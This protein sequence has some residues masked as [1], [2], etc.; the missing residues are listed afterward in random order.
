VTAARRRRLLARLEDGS[1]DILVGTH[2]VLEGDVSFA[3]LGFCVT[4]EQHRFGV[5]QR[6]S[7]TGQG[8]RVPHVLVMSATP[9]PRTLAMILYGDLDISEIRDRPAGRLPVKTYTASEGDRARIDRMMAARIAEGNQVYV[10][11]PQIEDSELTG[12]R[13][14]ESVFHRLSEEVFQDRRV[15]LMHGRLKAGE[16]LA[17]MEAFGRGEIDIL[18]STTVIEV[19]IDQP[20]ATLLVVE[21]AERFGLSQLH[22]LRGRVGRSSHP[23]YCVLVSD[24]QDRL[25]RERLRVLCRNDSGFAIADEDLRLRGPGDFFGVQQHGLPDFK[26]ANLYEDTELLRQAAAACDRIFGE[27]PLLGP[28]DQARVLEAFRTRYGDRLTRPGL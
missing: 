13:S 24:S 11:C 22:Q 2:A 14:A 6:V 19:G 1:L 3:R 20:N 15:A 8:E 23:S 18:V 7:L 16:K 28:T 12:L 21:N 26:V 5:R 27:D 17:V 4:D 10:V 9:I 25:I